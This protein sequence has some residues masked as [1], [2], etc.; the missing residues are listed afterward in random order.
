MQEAIFF[1]GKKPFANG[2]KR[3]EFWKI[4]YPNGFSE[5]SEMRHITTTTTLLR[6]GGAPFRKIKNA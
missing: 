6:G 4:G 5:R 1:I 3:S 2:A